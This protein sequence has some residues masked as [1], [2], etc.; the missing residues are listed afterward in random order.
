MMHRNLLR[1]RLN[2]I[3]NKFSSHRITSISCSTSRQFMLFMS[4]TTRLKVTKKCYQ[5]ELTVL[6][7]GSAVLASSFLLAVS[8]QRICCT[9]FNYN[10]SSYNLTS[11][12]LKKFRQDWDNYMVNTMNPE[13]SDD[14]EFSSL[15]SQEENNTLL[16]LEEHDNI[17]IHNSDIYDSNDKKL[18]AM[19]NSTEG[20]S[21]VDESTYDGDLDEDEPT[22]CTICLINRKGPCRFQWRKFERCMKKTNKN[23]NDTANN[24]DINT[25]NIHREGR[26]I[27][28]REDCDQ[29]MLP[30]ITCVQSYRNIY[31]LITNAL[32]QDMFI[33]DIEKNVDDINKV[34]FGD[35][36]PL[37][38][39]DLN[40][41]LNRVKQKKNSH[42]ERVTVKNNYQ[43]KQHLK[44]GND[45]DLI[46]AFVTINLVDT[47][48]GREIDIAYV[49]DQDGKILGFD[50]FTNTK[51]ERKELIKKQGHIDN[52]DS[53]GH[54]L[55]MNNEHDN[56]S[57]RKDVKN[58]GKFTF[59]INPETTNS[60]QVFALYKD[61]ISS[62]HEH[63]EE[64]IENSLEMKNNEFVKEENI[65]K[66]D[67]T[68][69]YSSII[70]LD[71]IKL[72]KKKK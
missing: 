9:S 57:E 66:S 28:L 34:Y 1:N 7:I 40:E 17:S 15:K 59:Y 55:Q 51:R 6:S 42:G 8:Y 5:R 61:N 41:W 26:S 2:L 12:K 39:L 33:D 43:I 37:S 14:E 27:S 62:M 69:Y 36:N 31:T 64:V 49:R 18:N 45:I 72:S 22:T 48:S 46:S 65:R 52:L 24:N 35:V 68:L 29:Y 3:V 56:M 44:D 60:I 30:W 54:I 20:A 19:I 16:S 71:D 38:F 50:Q 63:V 23:S 25:D 32:Y 58:I 4:G 11:A 47:L 21:E 10:H 53:Q 67:E 13:E 70:S